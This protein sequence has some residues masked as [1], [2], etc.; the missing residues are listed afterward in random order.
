MRKRA[1]SVT[2]AD[3]GRRKQGLGG[4]TTEAGAA[5]SGTTCRNVLSL[6]TDQ[7]R[8]E[9]VDSEEEGVS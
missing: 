6:D 7:T 5:K 1:N 8:R 2:D 9:N 3:M 4:E